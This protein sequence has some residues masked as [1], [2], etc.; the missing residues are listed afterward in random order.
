MNQTHLEEF[1]SDVEDELAAT[2]EMIDELGRVEAYAQRKLDS[3]GDNG[4][5]QLGRD[6]YKKLLGD[7]QD[8]VEAARTQIGELQNVAHFARQKLKGEGRTPAPRKP[9]AEAKPEPKVEPKAE[10]SRP[11]QRPVGTGPKTASPDADATYP[12]EKKDRSA[13]PVAANNEPSERPERHERQERSDR[14]ERSSPDPMRTIE[15]GPDGFPLTK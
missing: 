4:T 14:P 1:L 3:A 13:A 7:I 5:S 12:G 10:K 6:G 11:P 2:E 8:D 9:R 15:F